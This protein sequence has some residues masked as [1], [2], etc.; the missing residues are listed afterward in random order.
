LAKKRVSIP[1]DVAADVLFNS[2]GTCCRCNERGKSVQIHHIDEDPSNNGRENLALLCL[3]CHD[4]TQVSGGFGRH[5]N[6]ELVVRYRD[7]W[8]ARV[9][10]RREASDRQ[11][12]AKVTGTHDALERPREEAVAVL[13]AQP[14]ETISV[15]EHIEVELRDYSEDRSNA[16]REYVQSLLQR[17]ADLK[18]IAEPEWE[19]GVTARMVQASYDYID[20]L[21]GVLVVLAGFYARGSF[22]EEPQRYFA[23][24]VA[25][26]FSWHR[27]HLEPHGPGTG[28]TI[29]N[30]QVCS[31]VMDDVEDMIEDLAM[32]LVGYDEAFDS[33]AWQ[34]RWS[35]NALFRNPRFWRCDDR[36]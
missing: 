6:A 15:Q 24:R 23:E 26:C 18:S 20:K 7:A 25:D 28:G 14:S 33:E 19:S 29:V 36:R 5:L 27:S 2:D 35:G 16:I 1:A 10:Q 8:L 17:R 30:V 4:E 31:N 34:S 11:A 13:Q 32:S 12:I 21:E 3:Q 22:D 9:V